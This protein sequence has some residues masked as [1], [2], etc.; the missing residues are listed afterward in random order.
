MKQS[1]LS[2]IAIRKAK[3]KDKRY[4]ML[5][6]R[7]LVL[8]VMTTGFKFWR[9]IYREEGKRKKV[10]L[11]EYPAV[12]L[13]AA[14]QKADELREELG[15]G[16]SPAEVLNPP[17]EMTFYNVAEEWFSQQEPGWTPEHAKTVVYRLK[18]YLY[19]ALG[20]KPL[21]EI[22]APEL[23]AMLR[24]IE[25]SGR[26]ET[27]KRVRQIFGQVARFGVAC[28]YCTED[29]SL[30]LKDAMKAVKPHPMAALTQVEDIRRLVQ[31]MNDY[32]GSAVVRAAL[33]LSLY[34]LARPG[35]IRHAEWAEIDLEGCVWNIPA[36]K[37]KRRKPHAVPLCVQAVELLK[38]LRPLTGRWRWVFPSARN[39]GRP[40]SE[41]A[42]RV[43]LRSM[44]FSNDEMTPHG[45]RSLGSTRL[46]D[47]GYRPDV[48]EAALAHTQRGVRGI[49]NRGDYWA[50]RVKMMQEWADWLD[51]LSKDQ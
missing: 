15:R 6:G 5:D 22:T 47:M 35:E 41:N 43:A 20:D 36:E 17:H 51:S 19:P 8:E 38:E 16:V 48:I 12:S 18:A 14:R 46:N 40:M 4:S 42:V 11:G 44:G 24:P 9:L 13:V 27:A 21:R 26:V 45:F 31:A 23:L 25:S 49:Y 3:A 32:Q 2:D 28:G 7:G 33:W 1:A 34:T 39:D 37:M 30:S 50:E 10:T 29:V